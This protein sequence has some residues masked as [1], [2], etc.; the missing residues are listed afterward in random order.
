MIPLM[1]ISPQFFPGLSRRRDGVLSSNST[2]AM[3]RVSPG[4]SLRRWGSRL[5]RRRSA[6]WHTFRR[7]AAIGGDRRAVYHGAKVLILDEPTAAL[8]VKEAG[9]VLRYVGGTGAGNSGHPDHPQRPSCLSHRRPSPSSIGR[10]MEDRTFMKS[11]S[12][13]EVVSDG[14]RRRAG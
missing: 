3:R 13:Q 11:R 8:G 10:R 2:L 6:R 9:V 5:P 14:W 7:R 4:K 12:P 1:S